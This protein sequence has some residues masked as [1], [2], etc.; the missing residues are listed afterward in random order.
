MKPYVEATVADGLL[1]DEPL[2]AIDVALRVRGC[3]LGTRERGLRG[4]LLRTQLARVDGKQRLPLTNVGAS[5]RTV[6]TRGI[7]N[8]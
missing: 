5:V 7:A 6:T 2:I 3:R 4:A 8:S 1:R